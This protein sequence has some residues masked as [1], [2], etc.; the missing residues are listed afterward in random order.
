MEDPNYS[1][2][3]TPYS[4]SYKTEEMSSEETLSIGR[5]EEVRLIGQKEDVEVE[6]SE[7]GRN[8]EAMEE[9]E[10]LGNILE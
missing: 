2:P 7:E 3:S 8:E 10:I 6:V 1:L 5:G 4:E 9:V